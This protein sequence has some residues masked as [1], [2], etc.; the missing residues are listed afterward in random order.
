MDKRKDNQTG[1]YEGIKITVIFGENGKV[2][3][4]YPNKE[5]DGGIKHENR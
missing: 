2:S 5:Q 4:S 1:I 3:T